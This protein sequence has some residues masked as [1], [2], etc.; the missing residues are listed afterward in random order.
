MNIQP[1]HNL[2]ENIDQ[3]EALCNNLALEITTSF[4]KQYRDIQ[5]NFFDVHHHNPNHF[6]N[7]TGDVWLDTVFV[8]PSDL[9]PAC[10]KA[11]LKTVSPFLLSGEDHFQVKLQSL[12][13]L[14]EQDLL[15]R[16]FNVI[17][18]CQGYDRHGNTIT[19]EQA[20]GLAEQARKQIWDQENTTSGKGGEKRGDAIKKI[21]QQLWNERQTWVL[22][23]SSLEVLIVSS[24]SNSIQHAKDAL[25]IIQQGEHFV[26]SV[27]DTPSVD[28]VPERGIDVQWLKDRETKKSQESDLNSLEDRREQPLP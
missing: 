11:V 27:S 25:V 1:S 6:S 20:R 4:V 8:E 5:S 17:T 9:F 16:V 10:Y 23:V 12:K 19:K 15:R 3:Q 26:T 21:K 2:F 18:Q 28:I 24:I 7:N 22:D 14:V 13:T